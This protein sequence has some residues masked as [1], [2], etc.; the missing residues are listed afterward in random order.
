MS[1]HLAGGG[2][3][4]RQDRR[5][6]SGVMMRT[7]MT[8]TRLGDVMR[9]GAPASWRPAVFDAVVA[10]VLAG[11]IV[12]SSPAIDGITGGGVVLGVVAA[13]AIAATTVVPLIPAVV[14]PACLFGYLAAGNPGGPALLA[15]PVTMAVL[16]YR[17]PKSVVAV[18][19]ALV[20]AAVAGGRV[21]GFTE[22]GPI[23]T[24]GPA[25]AIAVAL[26][27]VTVR[28]QV[29]RRAERRRQHD[30]LRRQAVTGER[31]RIA[32]DLHDSVAHALASINVQSTVA[33]RL[34]ERDP[35]KAREALAAIRGASGDALDELGWLLNSLR[36]NSVDED[37]VD[38]NHEP[39]A[40]IDGIGELIA[41]A[42]NDGLTVTYQRDPAVDGLPIARQV[43]AAAYRVV[44]E[45]LSNVTRHAGPAARVRVHVEHHGATLRVGITDDGRAGGPAA[46]RGTGVGLIGMAERVQSTGGTLDVGPRSPGFAV[47]ATWPL[48]HV[49][50][51]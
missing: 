35:A 22:Y 38:E 31:L 2:H 45:A 51:P 9:P 44:Q 27:G 18:G 37:A 7:I 13:L 8:T 3:T 10:I 5:T 17:A 20:I 50:A 24:A 14:V 30:L 42:R 4:R 6:Y 1:G 39:G 48:P 34:L 11:L 43:S 33:D 46:P 25:W 40:S 15:G 26:V 29:D 28:T 19:V 23:G 49:G 12:G 21:V 16:G 47:Q 41:R 36:E 32:R